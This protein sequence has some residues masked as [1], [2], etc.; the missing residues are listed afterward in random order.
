MQL[1]LGEMNLP[2]DTDAVLAEIQTARR[3]GGL[4]AIDAEALAG[5]GVDLDVVVNRVEGELGQGVLD[6]GRH[7]PRR[8]WTGPPTSTQAKLILRAAQR[9][10]I[11]RGDR[12]LTAVHLLLGL[13]AHPGL[14]ADTL[15]R[16]GIT[17][18]TVL[19]ILEIRS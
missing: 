3:R 16:H 13:L 11:A 2:S 5:L 14:V 17:V 10:A 19:A 6:N 18:A 1:L 9:Q 15:G 12:G 8:G 7:S 4:S